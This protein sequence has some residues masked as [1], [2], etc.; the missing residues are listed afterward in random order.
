MPIIKKI[1]KNMKGLFADQQV[2]KGELIFMLEG[3]TYVSTPSRTSIQLQ[4]KH[5]EHWEGG[6]MN[7]HCNPT[8][9]IITKY[10]QLK[11]YA[12]VVAKKDIKKGDEITF[13]YET[14]EENRFSPFKCN[15][16]GRWIT[17]SQLK[18]L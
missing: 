6:H 15:C 3:E 11:A 2:T 8:A 14:T 1:K 17:G 4:D 9:E 16:H 13:D 10:N 18:Y 12:L 5:L 7:H